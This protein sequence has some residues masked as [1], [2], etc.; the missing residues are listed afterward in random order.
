MAEGRPGSVQGVE[1]EGAHLAGKSWLGH[2]D[3]MGPGGSQLTGW[4]SSCWGEDS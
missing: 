4:E 1:E 3:T 2:S